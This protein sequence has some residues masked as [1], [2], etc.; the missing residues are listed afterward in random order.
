MRPSTL[1]CSAT[2]ATAVTLTLTS[3]GPPVAPPTREL[4]TLN[5]DAY[6]RGLQ[7]GQQLSAK[8][9]GFYTTLLTASLF[10]YLGREQPDI[11]TLL[12]EYGN[13]RYKNGRFAYELLL[14]SAKSLERSIPLSAREEMRGIA[15]GSG[16]TYDEVLI[17]NTFVDS[18]L[19]V[20]GIA[21]AIRLSRAPVL[22]RVEVVEAGSDGADNDGDGMTDEAGEGVLDPYN[23][24]RGATFVELPASFTLKLRVRD[25]DGV[26]PALVRLQLGAE[27]LEATKT[28]LAA[29]LLEVSAN[30]T[31]PA[32]STLLVMLGA[33]DKKVLPN[34]PPDHASFMRDT[35]LLFTTRGAGLTADQVSW[36]VLSD[37]RTR[38][39]SIALSLQGPATAG[40]A[41]LIAQHFA[42]LDANTSYKHTAVFVHEP[43]KGRPFAYVGWAGVAWGFAG[44]NASGVGYACNSSDTL[45][46]SVVGAVFDQVADLSKAK[47]VAKGTPIG[48]AMRRVLE[49]ATDA[50]QAATITR[51]FEHAYG[52]SCLLGD[53]AGGQRAVEVDSDVF[54]EGSMGF[55]EYGTAE[56]L[57]SN[58]DGDLVIAS[59]Y[60]K[61]VNDIVRLTVAGQKIVPQREWA[62]TFFRS[63]RA[64]S[65]LLRDVKA[66]YG[67][68][69]RA[70]VQAIIS[71][72]EVVD[73]SDSMNAVVLDLK[74]RKLWSAH[75]QV[76]ATK[77][78]FIETEVPAP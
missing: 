3:C 9:K 60:T 22:E 28:E 64:A 32:A 8:I 61:N 24:T 49:T 44:M 58:G 18:T 73:M 4:V 17:L 75:G 43:D 27:P 7:H 65:H 63:R 76:P 41:P 20:R 1:V 16:L 26:D 33:G 66:A 57:S 54:K 23:P 42:L 46:N 40:G 72:P 25:S 52:W 10:P 74:N 30:V 48:F 50:A 12:T 69:D 19:A 78:P 62:G 38:P 37:G 11:A 47:L 35:E 68:L 31:A 21:L 67:Q 51:G 59:D 71:N 53:A 6:S 2:L 5:G 77:G 14:D 45:D 13:D 36:P 29:D 70:S 56:R 15:D 55:Y 39:P 34:P